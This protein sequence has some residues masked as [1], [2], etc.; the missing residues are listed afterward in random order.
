MMFAVMLWLAFGVALIVYARNAGLFARKT[1]SNTGAVLWALWLL[2][3][4]PIAAVVLITR[5]VAHTPAWL[6]KQ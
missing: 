4:W 3:G 5:G 1:S 6:R 2:L